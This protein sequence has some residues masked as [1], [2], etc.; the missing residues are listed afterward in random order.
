M[1]KYIVAADKNYNFGCCFVWVWNL[2]VD[3]AGGEE[4]EGV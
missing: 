1:V 3:I 2:V 4:A